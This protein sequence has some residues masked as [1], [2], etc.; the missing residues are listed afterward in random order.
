MKLYNTLTRKL[1]DVTPLNPPVVT[2]Y[3]CGP[4]VYDYAHVG[5]WFN[6]VRM[7]TLIRA[8]KSADFNPKW[9]MNIT[10][11]GHLVSDADEG[12]DKLEKGARREGK[13]AWEV[14]EFYTK[15]FLDG[16]QKLGMLQPNH[17]VKATDHIADQIALI[18]KLEQK[19][20]TYVIDDGV[21]YDTSKFEGYAAFARL[22]LDEL[23]EGAR[24]AANPQKRNGADFALWKLS[25]QDHTRDMEWDSPWGK[26]FPGW[27]IECS[28][29]SM[30]YLGDTL[31]IHTGGIDHI[32][33][34]H[35]N[36]IAQSEAATGQRF[37]N[38][39]LHGNHLLVNGEKIAKSLGNGLR[40]DEIIEKG[41]SPLVLR[42]HVLESHYR[43]QS[44]FSLE[45]LEA[46]R[47]R[48][49]GYQAMA[50]LRWQTIDFN[51][52]A[53][54]KKRAAGEDVINPIT[55]VELDR[56]K[57]EITES[58]ASDLNTPRA[59]SILSE[60]SS[61]VVEKLVAQDMKEKF[62]GLLE[63]ID[64]LLGLQLCERPD[65]STEQKQ[66]IADREAARQTK[67]WNKSDQLRD[68]LAKQGIA[69]RDTASGPIWYRA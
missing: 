43:S 27:H 52:E 23:Q 41:F 13:T 2:V 19:G 67:D 49:N 54:D 50:D 26:G 31:D 22:D 44:K 46:A 40:L 24:V 7:D 6:Y 12:E 4:T 14:A 10:D 9:V 53:A 42:L 38:L 8:L 63:I 34:H 32:P 5:H 16:W 29:M 68:E 11:V 21:Y 25:P 30:K 58:L 69:V 39:W 3:T 57:Q 20:Y 64:N 18:E 66:L 60:F 17:I 35:T 33:V 47:N 36:E 51:F 55:D 56:A 45:S 15:D 28:A 1:D 48:L 62:V 65:I 37:A 59:L 61:Q